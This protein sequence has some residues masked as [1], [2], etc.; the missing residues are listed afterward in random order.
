MRLREQL[1]APQARALRVA[2]G[3]EDGASIEP[4]L[5]AVATLSMLTA[6]AEESTVLCVVEDAHWLDSA[7]ADALLFCARRLGADRVLVFFSARDEAANPFR[8][9]GIPELQLTGLD[10]AAAREL[11]DQRLGERARW[12]SPNGSSRRAA[13]THWHCWSCPPSSARAARRVLATAG[14]A[15]P[16]HPC[17]AGLPRPQPAAAAASTVAAAARGRRRHRRPRRP[18]PCGIDPR[19]GRAGS[20]GRHRLRTPHRRRR[21]GEGATP[22]RALGALPG[23]HRG[24]TT[25]GAP[26]VGRRLGRSRRLRPRSVASRRSRLRARTPPSWRHLSASLPARSVAEATPPR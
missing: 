21:L 5:V 9:D 26:R 11:L 2:F 14:A 1:P 24:A 17:R 23:R 16:H 4:F 15:A 19:G 10:P 6:A 8:P 22:T 13:A 7:T 25:N 12:R 20:R 3:E 18:S